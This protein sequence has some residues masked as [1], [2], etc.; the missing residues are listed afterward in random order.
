MWETVQRQRVKKTN[1]KKTK[2]TLQRQTG[3]NKQYKNKHY[4]DKQYEN[5]YY[6][7]KQFKEKTLQRQIVQTKHYNRQGTMH[8]SFPSDCAP[9][10]GN[11]WLEDTDLGGTMPKNQSTFHFLRL[12]C[13][14][15]NAKMS[16]L[17]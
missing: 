6:K 1:S 12:T 10:S 3:Q 4:K 11:L 14:L 7:D 16:W 15:S 13:S 9:Q 5:E 8:E 2:Q 17:V